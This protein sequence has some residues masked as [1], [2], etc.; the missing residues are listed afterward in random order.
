MAP[1]PYHREQPPP[2][3]GKASLAAQCHQQD[4]NAPTDGKT[5]LAASCHQEGEAVNRSTFT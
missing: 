5:S 3:E 2:T 1:L 4:G